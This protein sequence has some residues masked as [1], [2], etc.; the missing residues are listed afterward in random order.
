MNANERRRAGGGRFIG[1]HL[2]KTVEPTGELLPAYCYDH[3]LIIS[4]RQD[5]LYLYN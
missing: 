1:G 4:T 5:G 2:H 3:M